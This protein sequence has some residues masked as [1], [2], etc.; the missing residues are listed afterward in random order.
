AGGSD[1]GTTDGSAGTAGSDGGDGG[2][3]TDAPSD[4]GP[5]APADSSGD[6]GDTGST[7]DGGDAGFCSNFCDLMTST[8]ATVAMYP[9]TAPGSCATAC[10]GFTAMQQS[11]YSYFVNLAKNGPS[12]SHD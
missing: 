4:R 10:N 1:G 5:D 11:C 8:C 6:R 9:W 12:G 3:T 7:G 2:P